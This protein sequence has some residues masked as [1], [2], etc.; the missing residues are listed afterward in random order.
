MMLDVAEWRPDILEEHVE[1][2]ESLWNRRLQAPRSSISDR[3]A[4]RRLDRRIEA[5][6]DA[7]VLAGAH[8]AKFLEP[9]FAGAE[10]PA[11]AA[12]ASVVALA[13]SAEL[14]ARLLD[15]LVTAPP[16]ARPGFWAAL[17]LRAGPLLRDALARV[18]GDADLSAGAMAALAGHDDPRAG[19]MKPERTLVDPSPVA[20]ALGWKAV[21]RLGEAS[22]IDSG[23]YQRGF[24][25]DDAAVRRAALEAAVATRLGALMGHLR[26]AAATPDPARFEEQL[27][28]AI[29]AGASE[30][31]VV[32]ALGASAALGWERYRILVA[33]GR[34]PA[35]EDLLAVMRGKDQVEAALAGSAF[36]RITGVSVALARRMPLVPAGTEPDDFSDEI[37]G[38]DVARAEKAWSKL[39]GKMAGARWTYGVDAEATP[40]E[41]L[42]DAVDL[43]ASWA[44]DLRAAFVGKRRLRFDHERIWT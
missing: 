22:R 36:Y 26:Q 38:C 5:H 44:A 43:E 17:D 12:A 31:Q 14:V 2:L 18:T 15:A 10:P 1:T 16:E 30:L 6:A 28:F 11:L 24:V 42:P 20:R 41:S 37:A 33:C 32:R 25:D 35:V 3:V 29:L 4:L 19:A 34:A 9:L 8:A 39:K 7:L 13:E 40:P 23:Y 27:L 21:R